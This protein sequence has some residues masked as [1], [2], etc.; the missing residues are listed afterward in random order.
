MNSCACTFPTRPRNSKRRRGFRLRV[1]NPSSP[2]R[3]GRRRDRSP[4]AIRTAAK[5]SSRRSYLESTNL[6]KVTPR[7]S[8]GVSAARSAASA[9]DAHVDRDENDGNDYPDE[10]RR[11][12]EFALV[13]GRY[14]PVGDPRSSER[15]DRTEQNRHDDADV[16]SARQDEPRHCT[17][18][19]PD[20]D[21]TDDSSDHLDRL[22]TAADFTHGLEKRKTTGVASSGGRPLCWLVGKLLLEGVLYL[23]AR[24]FQARLRLVDLAFIF[25]AAVSGGLADGLFGLAGDVVNL[26]A[27]FVVGAHALLLPLDMTLDMT[28]GH[29]D[30]RRRCLP[31]LLPLQTR[32]ATLARCRSRS[33]TITRTSR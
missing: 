26:V 11:E 10:E 1:Y 16:L 20:K 8:I 6:P 31:G 17:D 25:G 21:R 30:L 19:E 9:G 28:C 32:C 12:L 18:N 23:L 22:P 3:I 33:S 13:G 14:Q 29:A 2:I 4:T 24:V 15:P 5:S 7:A 27:H